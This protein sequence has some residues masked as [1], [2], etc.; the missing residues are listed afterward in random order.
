MEHRI[1]SDS[2]LHI[3]FVVAGI[4]IAGEACIASAACMGVGTAQHEQYSGVRINMIILGGI[5]KEAALS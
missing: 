4:R 5:L 2:L 1:A 3:H